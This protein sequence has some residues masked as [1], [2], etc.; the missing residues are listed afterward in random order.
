MVQ[1]AKGRHVALWD[2]A[3]LLVLTLS[4]LSAAQP[5]RGVVALGDCSD[6]Q[7]LTAA[8][9]FTTSL[10][11]RH[12]PSASGMAEIIRS[13]RPQ[14][15]RTLEEIRRQIESA[16]T[17][18]YSGSYGSAAQLVSEALH[19][20][21]RTDPGAARWDLTVQARL[22][23]GLIHRGA[24]RSVDADQSFQAVLRLAP[25]FELDTNFFAPSVNGLFNRMRDQVRD[26]PKGRLVVTSS[27]PGASVYL[28]GFE[29]GHTPFSGDFV[30]G[31]YPLQLGFQG[32]HSFPR[33][34]QISRERDAVLTVD[35]SFE[36]SVLA[37]EPLCL[38]HHKGAGDPFKNA[39]KLGALI[40]ADEIIVLRQQKKGA[41]AGWVT[42]SLLSVQ[43]GQSIREGSLQTSETGDFGSSG[44]EL[45]T[46]VVTGEA[47]SAV[48]P[49]PKDEGH[50]APL[51]IIP[52]KVGAVQQLEEQA[53]RKRHLRWVGYG[54][55]GVAVMALGGSA[56]IWMGALEDMRTLEAR[57]TGRSLWNADPKGAELYASLRTRSQ[58]LNG[59]LITGGVASLT[60]AALLWWG[61]A[62]V[63]PSLSFGADTSEGMVQVQGQF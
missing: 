27:P 3:L 37:G 53:R 40:G 62:G 1:I 22:L 29:V 51:S 9:S 31:S 58:V 2:L 16:D 20:L 10:F 60:S 11:E 23:E 12:P 18:F 8:R 42:V 48:Q 7:L 55:G 33:T 39:V 4:G 21:E 47:T 50:G 26:L 49:A 36:G 54:A 61:H 41:G 43:S 15:T 45:V 34:V 59:L 35:L 32:T 5:R 6:A 13:L 30:P 24:Q 46:F 25:R 19:E 63:S 56:L 38:V 17:L 14:A 28:D 57:R 52:A 44:Q